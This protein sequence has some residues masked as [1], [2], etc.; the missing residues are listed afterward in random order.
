MVRDLAVWT[1]L[2]LGIII[3]I[4]DAY[5]ILEHGRAASLS[6]RLRELARENPV[7]PFAAGCLI[8]HLFGF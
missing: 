4:V 1:L 3:S 8:A 7:L 6:H 5:L 2:A